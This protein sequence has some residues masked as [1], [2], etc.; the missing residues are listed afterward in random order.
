MVI[1]SIEICRDENKSRV[2]TCSRCVNSLTEKTFHSH[3]LTSFENCQMENITLQTKIRLFSGLL[4][5]TSLPS[6]RYFYSIF[7]KNAK[8][9]QTF[10]NAFSSSFD[11]TLSPEMHFVRLSVIMLLLGFMH[12]LGVRERDRERGKEMLFIA[13]L[14]LDAT[15]AMS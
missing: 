14:L 2:E 10:V 9:R 3:I 7:D 13:H 6:S 4:K 5:S 8:V 12:A 15:I 11:L 1:Y